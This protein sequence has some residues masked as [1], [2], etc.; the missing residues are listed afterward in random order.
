MTPLQPPARDRETCDYCAR[1][2]AQADW[3][4]YRAQC[5]GC[6]VRSLAQ[7]PQFH[8]AGVAGSIAAPYRKALGLIFGDDWRAGHERVKAEH[9]RIKAMRTTACSHST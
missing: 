3:P 5:R 9:A 1:A 4:L 8:A 6:A 2:Q 7:G